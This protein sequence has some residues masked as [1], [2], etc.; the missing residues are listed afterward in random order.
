MRNLV[1]ALGFVLA[2]TA[3]EDSR[4][5]ERAIIVFDASGSMWGQIGGETKISIAQKTLAEVLADIPAAL[6]L[7]FVAY[8]HREKG[9]CADIE[10]MVPPGAATGSTIAE[11]ANG[12]TP[13]GKTPISDAVRQAAAELRYT[14]E[15][16]TVILIT[17]GI[18]TCDADPC[19]VAAE[20]ER[21]GV[22]LTVHVVGFGLSEEEGRQV[23]CLAENTG[24]EYFSA[25][26][27]GALADALETTVT[28][29]QPPPAP[30]PAPVPEPEPEA[31]P[32]VQIQIYL[33]DGVL[34]GGQTKGGVSWEIVPAGEGTGGA[35]PVSASTLSGTYVLN[36]I[37]P[38]RY[39]VRAK[40]ML[41]AGETE[42]EVKPGE[43]SEVA[44]V[45]NAGVIRPRTVLSD[46]T[47]PPAD[48]PISWNVVGPSGAV[49]LGI[50]YGAETYD[51]VVPPGT[52]TV[53]VERASVVGEQPVEIRAGET[54]EVTVVLKPGA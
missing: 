14:Q 47:P 26:D 32:S 6:E 7:G 15:K 34:F 38:G 40:A 41:A 13:L 42:F 29:V 37:E 18:E 28:V 46:G 53:R 20:L 44:V 45:L 1:F 43:Q 11:A 27:A 23:S 51:A 19:A 9:N 30:E 35:A 24:G 5:A 36:S 25:G 22:D 4:A 54:E 17:D 10:L 39:T 33:A 2:L 31:A 12:L 8:G 52:W 21:A 48:I 50:G 49:L 16:A 3:G